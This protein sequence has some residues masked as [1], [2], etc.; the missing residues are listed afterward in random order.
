MNR[1][2]IVF[3]ALCLLILTSCANPT[4]TFPA[5]TFP[6]STATVSPS[7]STPLPTTVVTGE[8]TINLSP[9]TFGPEVTLFGAD[10]ARSGLYN[11][12]A[13]RQLPAQKWQVNIFNDFLGAPLLVGNTLYIGTYDGRVFALDAATGETRWSSPPTGSMQSVERSLAVAGDVI[14]VGGGD[15]SLDALDRRN[16]SPLWSLKADSAIY[17]APLIINNQVL[18]ATDYTAYAAELET[19]KL[20]WQSSINT[21][22][23]NGSSPAYDDGLLFIPTGNDLVALNAIDGSEVWHVQSQNW[24]WGV[25]VS[26]SHVYAG[27]VD[28]NLYAY[29]AKTGSE[30]WKFKADNQGNFDFWSTP[31][32]LDDQ[33]FIGNSDRNLYALNVL[34]GE[35]LWKFKTD[36]DAIS[37]PVIAD[38]VI[39]ISDSNHATALAQHN[40]YALDAQ[41]GEELWKYQPSSTFLTGPALGNS[42]L[43]LATTGDVFALH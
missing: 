32:L 37:D 5:P 13:I 17:S 14:L 27:N 31:A 33:L 4:A 2:I 1:P 25:A 35:L 16:G 11:L 24:F 7:T 12:P 19:G 43:Y 30:L 40:L 15:G 21:S 10:P 26:H 6:P 9:P 8:P 29:D 23:G 39:Y 28:S 18:F 41:T 34:T 22:N 3:Y 20:I 36:G 38:G 42:A